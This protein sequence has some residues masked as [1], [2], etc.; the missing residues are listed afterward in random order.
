[1][2]DR[3]DDPVMSQLFSW[4][5]KYG[6]WRQIELDAL[7]ARA[8]TGDKAAEAAHLEA[9]WV[10]LP[11]M[12][13]INLKER[14][15]GHDVFAFLATWTEKMTPR[16]A[17][18]IHLGLTSSDLVDNTL[19]WQLSSTVKFY[20]R[21]L[22][23]LSSVLDR[24]KN[25]HMKTVRIGR[26]HGQWAEPTMLASRFIGWNETIGTIRRQSESIDSALRVTKTPGAVGTMRLFGLPAS[27]HL[28]NI[29]K[30]T[31]V[32][33]TQVVPRQ[34]VLAWAG[35]VLQIVSLVEEIALEIR[36]SSRTEV[37]EMR[38]G[39]ATF[40]VGSSAMAHKRNPIG[41]EQLSGLGRVARAQFAAI[42]E[43]AGALHHERD[44]SNSSVERLAV[45]DLAILTGYMLH[46]L[47][48]ILSEL[49]INTARMHEHYN[50]AK[51]TAYIQWRLQELGVPYVEASAMTRRWS[52]LGGWDHD[53][54]NHVNS[55]LD[56]ED[57]IDMTAFLAY[58]HSPI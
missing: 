20:L 57:R 48:I 26:T 40:R 3:Y 16:T 11:S 21:D 30:T 51:D 7:Q 14:G 29:R 2:I 24:L 53:M 23:R 49:K 5:S 37:G 31:L 45:P 12:T 39:G 56:Q 38:E 27:Q 55:F 43:T 54:L 36:L 35:W 41:S 58:L 50:E 34:R 33:S 1:M 47:N 25:A 17:S 6:T 8:L 28:A 42:A 32:Q 13:E 15:S 52:V 22:T 10:E 19:F 18:Q 44:I 9:K 4:M 46:Q